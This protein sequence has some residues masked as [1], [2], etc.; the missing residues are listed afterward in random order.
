MYKKFI[1][2]YGW[3]TSFSMKICLA[4]NSYVKKKIRNLEYFSGIQSFFLKEINIIV[5][6]SLKWS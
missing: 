2:E 6:K 4:I 5:L 1:Q 3:S